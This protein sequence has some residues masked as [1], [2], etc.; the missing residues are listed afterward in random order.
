MEEGRHQQPFGVRTGARTTQRRGRMSEAKRASLADL[1]PQWS[2]DGPTAADPAGLDRAFARSAPRLLDIGGGSGEATR[3]WA[4]DHP[5]HDVVALELHRPGIVRLV[6]DLDAEGPAN[7]RVA[8]VDA[9]TVVAALAPGTYEAVRV[10][11]PDPWPKRR[12]V[13]RR[14]VDPA[15]VQRVVD[16]L[17]QG[18][19]LHLATD[20]GDYGEQMRAAL[21]TD[22]RLDVEVAAR[23]GDVVVVPVA[24]VASVAAPP[25]EPHGPPVWWSPKP[26]RP[27]TAYEQRGID[28]GRTIVDLVSRRAR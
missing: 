3:A 1:G 20:W 22:T 18:G 16:L 17:P 28:A 7:V 26:D 9:T 6:R 24:D 2:I 4:A 13:G 27:I 5:D 23:D 25:T 10:L 21:A 14:L 19:V 8:E 11:F 15:F 12:H